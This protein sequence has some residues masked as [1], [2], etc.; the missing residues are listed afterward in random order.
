MRIVTYSGLRSEC[1]SNND[2]TILIH[3][4]VFHFSSL[5]GREKT[6]HS[7]PLWKV[8]IVVMLGTFHCF[9]SEK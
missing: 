7:I 6:N 8:P 9:A 3:S 1:L 5:T 4:S 2:K